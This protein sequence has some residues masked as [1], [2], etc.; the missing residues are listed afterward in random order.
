MPKTHLTGP[1]L[2]ET[3]IDPK[4]EKKARTSQV[5]TVMLSA[6]PNDEKMGVLSEFRKND[7]LTHHEHVAFALAVGRG[8]DLCRTPG[9]VKQDSSRIE[10]FQDARVR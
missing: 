6:L 5:T 2:S 1:T 8:G 4:K 3:L 7:E 10:T 9:C